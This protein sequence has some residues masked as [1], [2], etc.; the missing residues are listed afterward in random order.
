MDFMKESTKDL[1]NHGYDASLPTC[2]ILEG[3][4]M[5][6]KK[7][8]IIQLLTELSGLSAKGSFVILNFLNGPEGSPANI[9]YMGALL[10]E[11]GWSNEQIFTYGEPNFSFGRFPEGKEPVTA[12]G[13]GFYDLA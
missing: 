13:F 4:V 2:W 5:Y 6:M 3:L 12:M 1:P 9:D 8:E 10:K 11:K 7:P